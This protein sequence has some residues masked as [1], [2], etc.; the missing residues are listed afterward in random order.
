MPTVPLPPSMLLAL[1]LTAVF[2]VPLTAAVNCTDPLGATVTETGDTETVMFELGGGLLEVEPLLPPP[3]HAVAK[4][5]ISTQSI[6]T[7]NDLLKA[8]SGVG[9]VF[10]SL[11]DEN[12]ASRI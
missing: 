1:Q 8:Q 6:F 7:Q 2:V 9:A 3:P 11:S 12:S 5:A 10:K 4:D